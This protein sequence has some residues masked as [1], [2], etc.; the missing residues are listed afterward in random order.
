MFF[1]VLITIFLISGC[2]TNKVNCVY[3]NT[4][5][6]NKYTI[7]VKLE[8]N[9][10]EYKDSIAFITYE[11]EKLAKSMCDVFKTT[12]D[13]EN[14]SCKEKVI[15]IKKYYSASNN[16]KEDVIKSFEDRGYTCK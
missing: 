3:E 10:D 1:L 7:E 4:A 11:D 2:S 6:N 8:F 15:T 9:K 16:N 12:N 5:E 14:V 13:S